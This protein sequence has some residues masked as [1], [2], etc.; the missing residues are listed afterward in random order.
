MKLFCCCLLNFKI[1]L[2]LLILLKKCR[3]QQH[4]CI[5]NTKLPTHTRHLT[6]MVTVPHKLITKHFNLTLAISFSNKSPAQE[7]LTSF[8]THHPNLAWYRNLKTRPL[9]WTPHFH[10]ENL[11][12]NYA[13]QQKLIILFPSIMLCNQRRL[14]FQILQL[15]IALQ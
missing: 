15:L 9:I 3:N 10:Q 14:I 6:K 7:C 2:D 5:N 11:L 12:K 13:T 4:L 8:C 1:K